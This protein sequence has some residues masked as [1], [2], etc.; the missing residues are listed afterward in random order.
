MMYDGL[1]FCWNCTVLASFQRC[2]H[3]AHEDWKTRI[4]GML[5]HFGMCIR[6]KGPFAY[7]VGSRS[8]SWLTCLG[9]FRSSGGRFR[10]G[11]PRRHTSRDS[12]AVHPAEAAA[13][14]RLI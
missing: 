3:D 1:Q 4:I 13:Y 7:R 10:R 2:N 11:H 6:Y 8:S 14:R 5:I 12:I 9:A